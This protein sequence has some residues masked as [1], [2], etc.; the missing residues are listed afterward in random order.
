MRVAGVDLGVAWVV[1]GVWYSM[2]TGSCGIWCR[3]GRG[4][5]RGAQE[6][7]HRFR[8]HWLVLQV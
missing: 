8:R 6:Q 3:G 2:E 1:G 4:W 7:V 5:Q